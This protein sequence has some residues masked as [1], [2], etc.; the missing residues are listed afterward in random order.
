METNEIVQQNNLLDENTP[1]LLDRLAIAEVT[2]E[3]LDEEE[4][5][6]SEFQHSNSLEAIYF[7]LDKLETQFEIIWKRR[8][9]FHSIP[10]K[11]LDSIGNSSQPYFSLDAILRQSCHQGLV[12]FDFGGTKMILRNN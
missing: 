4:F 1:N 2:N 9:L 5:V 12:D 10:I 8:I 3:F 7:P 11:V 6:Q